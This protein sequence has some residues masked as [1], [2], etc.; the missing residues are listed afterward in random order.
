MSIRYF[1]LGMLLLLFSCTDQTYKKLPFYKVKAANGQISYLL[2]ST[3]YLK[4]SDFSAVI[5]SKMFEAFEKSERYVSLTDI[6]ASDLGLIKDIIRLKDG[7]TLKETL[8]EEELAVFNKQNIKES[9]LDSIRV[10]L[11]FYLVDVYTPKDTSFFNQ[12][13][14]WLKKAVSKN[15][16]IDGLLSMQ[17]YYT[18]IAKQKNDSWATFVKKNKIPDYKKQIASNQKYIIKNSNNRFN[19]ELCSSKDALFSSK[20]TKDQYKRDVLTRG[21]NN[22]DKLL[23]TEVNFIVL[24]LEYF[25]GKYRIQEILLSKGYQLKRIH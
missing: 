14:F 18:L 12:M 20:T 16:R 1:L 10:K 13:N 19:T 23:N 25:Y 6:Q 22:I 3:N 21:I 8:T 17:D 7:N 4:E 11:P 5:S 9:T 15:K 2:A 24:D